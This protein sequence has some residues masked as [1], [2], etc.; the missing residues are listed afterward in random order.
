MAAAT[1]AIAV[2]SKLLNAFASVLDWRGNAR[3]C[4]F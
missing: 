4:R 3:G 2:Y 1:I